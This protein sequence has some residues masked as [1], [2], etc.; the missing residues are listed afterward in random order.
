[1]MER[2]FTLRELSELSGVA[3]HLA[4]IHDRRF[5]PPVLKASDQH[6]REVDVVANLE[7]YRFCFIEKTELMHSLESQLD[8][9]RNELNSLPLYSV[10]TSSMS[11]NR[12]Q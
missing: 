9:M 5:V 4:N 6:G 1:M 11:L 8:Q 7:S 2:E 10:W 3:P 12:H